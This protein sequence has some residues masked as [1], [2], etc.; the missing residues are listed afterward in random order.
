MKELFFV[1]IFKENFV[2]HRFDKNYLYT[3]IKQKFVKKL[4]MKIYK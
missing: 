4:W 2:I 3:M 1:E